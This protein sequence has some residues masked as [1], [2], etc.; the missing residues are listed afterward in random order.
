MATIDL[1][2]SIAR[3]EGTAEG[4]DADVVADRGTVTAANS[5]F[6]TRREL[7]AGTVTAPGSGTNL[8]ADPLFNA[9]AF[10]L[11]SS[12]PLVDRG[13]PAVV[14]AG[15]LDLAGNPRKAGAA[16]DIGAFEYQPP[17]PPPPPPGPPANSA[18]TLGKVSMTNTVFAPV[19]THSASAADP[20]R[21]RERVKRGT[22]F[23][24]L[25]SEAS[26][27]TIAIERR[28]R[29][30]RARARARGRCVRPKHRNRKHK[31]CTR[32][33]GAGVLKAVEQ[34]G[35]QSMPFSGRLKS[36]ALKPGKYRARVY[37]KDAGGARSSERRVSFR[38]VR[39][40]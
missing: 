16:P 4:S 34:A 10:T 24:Y 5:D 20:K 11:P 26:T 13:D 38:V 30:K 9:G 7:N 6:A 36:K 32:W 40:R 21:S 1:R 35:S 18:P 29:G 25:L 14:T 12:S 15:E 37:A 28:A 8:I 3:I 39:A 19:S 23:R 22:R 17:A 33:L 31:S 2:N 27:V